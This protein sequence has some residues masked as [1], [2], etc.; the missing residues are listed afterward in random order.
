MT[1]LVGC[2][3]LDGPVDEALRDAR[4]ALLVTPQTA[5]FQHSS[6][7]PPPGRWTSRKLRPRHAVKMNFHLASFVLLA[8]LLAAHG[9]TTSGLNSANN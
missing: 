4:H 7:I 1:S 3:E 9:K 2:Q 8:G 5:Q 6:P